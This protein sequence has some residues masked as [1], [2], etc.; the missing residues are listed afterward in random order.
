M[1]D[2][3][4]RHISDACEAKECFE[5]ERHALKLAK[6][7]AARAEKAK[8]KAA[9]QAKAKAAATAAKKTKTELFDV[10]VGN[11]ANHATLLATSTGKVKCAAVHGMDMVEFRI[12]ARGEHPDVWDS[13]FM[14]RPDGSEEWLGN[15]HSAVHRYAELA[16]AA[17]RQWAINL[18]VFSGR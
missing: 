6:A 8:V 4:A 15:R 14:I 1:P 2:N 10:F 5:L 13:T 17:L 12:Q 16:A 18:D 3:K 7:K 9:E 11:I